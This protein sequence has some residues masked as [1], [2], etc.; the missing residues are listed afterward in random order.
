M[1]S[2]RESAVVLVG[3]ALGGFLACGSGR[4]IEEAVASGALRFSKIPDSKEVTVTVQVTGC[5]GDTNYRFK[6]T[7]G[8]PVIVNVVQ[9]EPNKAKGTTK[10][11]SEAVGRLDRTLDIYRTAS[12]S[13]RY[14]YTV[15]VR[16]G[17]PEGDETLRV[18]GWCALDKIDAPED[19]GPLLFHQLAAMAG[20]D[21]G[22]MA[23][24]RAARRHS[25]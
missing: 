6:L 5:Y 13:S 25:R 15:F 12:P 16:I 3:L 8:D 10:I 21:G 9:T 17:W 22:W 19:Q 18:D 11:S 23:L 7:G 20:I 1:R 14:D 24:R 2:Q 4:A